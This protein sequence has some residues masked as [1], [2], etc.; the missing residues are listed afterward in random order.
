ML[1][2]TVRMFSDQSSSVARLTVGVGAC[3]IHVL[4][5][6]LERERREHGAGICAADGA[7]FYKLY[8]HRYRVGSHCMSAEAD[9]G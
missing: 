7:E 6:A 4:F 5:A 1:S 9:S 8:A 3:M 2:S